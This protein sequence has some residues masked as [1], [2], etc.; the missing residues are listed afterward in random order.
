MSFREYLPE[1]SG[2]SNPPSKAE[3]EAVCLILQKYGMRVKECR[4]DVK[5]Q[6]FYLDYVDVQAVNRNWFRD[7]P[8]A[9]KICSEVD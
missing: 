8:I 5:M 3:F 2:V 9:L 6:G 1:N 7:Y 4:D